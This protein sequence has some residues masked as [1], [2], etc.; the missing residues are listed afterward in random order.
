MSG[1]G[2]L[3]LLILISALPVFLILLWFHLSRFPMSMARCLWA[4]LAGAAA[5]FPALMLQRL[6]LS[7]MPGPGTFGGRW[8]PLLHIFVRIAF[9]EELSRLLALCVFFVISGDFKYTD[10]FYTEDSRSGG[11]SGFPGIAAWGSAAGLLA[12]LGFSIVESAAYGAAEFRIVLLRVFTAAP[13]HGACGAR[14]GSALLVFREQPRRAVFRF[15]SAVVIHG[16][17]NITI[18]GSGIS[19]LFGIL[20]SLSALISSV[21]EIRGAVNNS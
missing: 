13:L 1:L 16:I 11:V 6:F 21:L 7:L 2:V 12:G 18:A 20:I 14:I 5:L 9:T 4:T 19:V 17:Y 10:P 15:L 8:G 3:L